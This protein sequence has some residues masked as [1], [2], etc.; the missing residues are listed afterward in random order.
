MAYTT[1]PQAENVIKL[2]NQTNRSVFLTGKAGSGKTTLLKHI[3][4]HTHKN[5]VV[6][7]PTGIAALNAGGVTIHSM[8]QL[9]PRGFIPDINYKGDL[10]HLS[11]E[12][13]F[14]LQ[15]AFKMSGIRQ[16]VIRSLEL[17]VID[18]V[19]MLRADLLDSMDL[20]LRKIRKNSLPM[21][22]VQV[23]FIGDLQQLPPVVKP[24]EWEIL[25]NYY[26]GI[27][28]FHARV[29]AEINPLYVE[30][31]K[32]FR[33]KDEN[34]IKLLNSLR[35][36][37]L[38][39]DENALLN[40][41]IQKNYEPFLDKGFIYLTT[42]N[43]KADEINIQKLFH[44]IDE[45]YRFN[46]EIEGEFPEKMYPLDPLLI[47]KRNARV[48][49][50]K[51][52]MGE[53]K[54]FY[55]GKMGII[56]SLGH[57]EVIVRFE[58][59]STIEVEKFEWTNVRYKTNPNTQE[60][61]ED[62][63]GTFVQY[64]LKLAWAITVHKSQGL[65]FEKAIL[66]I[67]DVFQPGQAYVALS[68][69]TSLEGLILTDSLLLKAIKNAEDV[70]QYAQL[71]TPD[72]ELNIVLKNDTLK[73][74]YSVITKSFDMTEL[75][76][77]WS[78]HFVTYHFTGPISEKANSLKWAQNL[79]FDFR[80]LN[81]ISHKFL[82]WLNNY[83]SQSERDFDI[84]KQKILGAYGYY[85]TELD[86]LLEEQIKK[87]SE[88]RGSKKV[89]EYLKEVQ[90][91]D[92]L[93]TGKILDISKAKNI[94]NLIVQGQDMNKNQIMDDF[95]KNYKRNKVKEV[96]KSLHGGQLI[97]EDEY[98]NEDLEYYW[99]PI[100][101]IKKTKE[102]TYEIT[103]RLW[104]EKKNILE[105]AHERKVTTNTIESHLARLVTE[106][107]LSIVDVMTE[108]RVD[109]LN[110]YFDVF[111]DS[112]TDAKEI[113]GDEYSYGELRIYKNFRIIMDI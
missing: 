27:F 20:V 67:N 24:E 63:L 72:E 110:K 79:D 90:E 58:D 32:I 84:L 73:F 56:D 77:A 52:D 31:K 103:Y 42:H 80:N 37:E 111:P 109:Q 55:N 102:S 74:L 21:G 14:T 34:F 89:K 113:V 7:A 6:V 30:L 51:N 25:R 61:E 68:R 82:L 17:L 43:R 86:K 47:L 112:I 3:L 59:G 78:K 105:I 85:F 104:Q 83:F 64:P 12:T 2:I 33:Q 38:G 98:A 101:K 26:N 39:N 96:L 48:M 66:D 71:E 95:T 81:S 92:A 94:C 76:D 50:V 54:R 65:T 49:F 45:E 75:F 28:F 60:I 15:K 5:T 44:L 97:N 11:M 46:A 53:D 91:I 88:L 16:S 69:L 9:A 23:L 29:I 35:N 10:S 19:S 1:T 99:K 22:G 57:Q 93:L 108:D 41:Y 40:R 70:M 106:G 62:V 100:K 13:A 107:K 36:N 87:I 18:E 4:F 8:F